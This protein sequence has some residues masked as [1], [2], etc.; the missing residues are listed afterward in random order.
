FR[1]A[2]VKTFGHRACFVE[3]RSQRAD[4][5]ARPAAD[6]E[7]W[8][9][10]ATSARQSSF[11]GQITYLPVTNR[12]HS[13]DGEV[14]SSCDST[15]PSRASLRSFESNDPKS[16]KRSLFSRLSSWHPSVRNVLPMICHWRKTSKLTNISTPLL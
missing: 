11:F 1:L 10:A 14:A 15:V 4:K 16:V 5:L 6:G 3:L 9:T 12:G 8:Q 7:E 13:D 2:G